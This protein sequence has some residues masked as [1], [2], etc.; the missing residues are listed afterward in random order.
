MSCSNPWLTI[1]SSLFFQRASR[2]TVS[3]TDSRRSLL[4][5]GHSRSD[6]LVI[7]SSSIE[8]DGAPE[9]VVDLYSNSLEGGA[10]QMLLLLILTTVGW[11]GGSSDSA[12]G[13]F[14]DRREASLLP[15]VA[16][17]GVAVED[18][19]SVRAGRDSAP[20]TLFSIGMVADSFSWSFLFLSSTFVG[21]NLISISNMYFRTMK[22]KKKR[23]KLK[24]KIL[25]SYLE[26][27][28]DWCQCHTMPDHLSKK[29][30]WVFWWWSEL[31]EP[32]HFWRKFHHKNYVWCLDAPRKF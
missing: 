24:I 25:W 8:L 9:I 31:N 19:D 12:R 4:S 14:Y 6:I 20:L 28:I 30:V 27:S 1:S 21:L 18:R 32:H 22:T 11:R 13:K 2:S 15:E 23:K 5:Q 3:I 26:E 29:K 7:A 10:N 17:K 16:G